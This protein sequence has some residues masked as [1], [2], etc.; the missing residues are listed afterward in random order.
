MSEDSDP[1][2]ELDGPPVPTARS[3][4]VP[5]HSVEAEQA[6][7]GGAML[8]NNAWVQCAGDSERARL[9][10]PATPDHLRSDDWAW[11]KTI[12]RWMW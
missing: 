11:P 6:V 12:S 5:P 7:L 1:F 3:L 8:D 4:K 2:D 10:P 9:L